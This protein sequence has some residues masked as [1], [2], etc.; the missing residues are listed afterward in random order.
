M[1]GGSGTAKTTTAQMFFDANTDHQM[2]VKKMNFA[3]ATTP[4]MFQVAVEGQLDKH[5]GLRTTG[6]KA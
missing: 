5:G 4:G 1:I 6:W 3:S 2:L